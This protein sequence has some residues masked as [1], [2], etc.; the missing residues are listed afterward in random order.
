MRKPGRRLL[1]VVVTVAMVCLGGCHRTD[2]D[3]YADDL[4]AKVTVDAMMGHL[5]TLQDIADA[6]GGNRRS[7][8]PGYQ[9][10]VDYV[11]QALRDKGF[12]VS[13]PEFE[14]DAFFVDE[15]SMTVDGRAI[16]VEAITHSASGPPG[17]VRGRLVVTRGAGC[18]PEDYEGLPARGAVV[19]VDRGKCWLNAKSDAAAEAGAAA[20]VIVNDQAEKV[21]SIILSGEQ[22]SR[23]PVVGVTESAGADLKKLTGEAAV[24]VV[25][26]VEK[27]KARNVIAQTRRGATDSV[28]M[29]GGHLDSVR[30]GP[31]IN[32][33]G[34]GV[35]AI[36]E[37]A[38]QMGSAPQLPYAVRFAFWGGEEEGL[39]G[40][41]H[42]TSSLDVEQLK[43]I[44]L[45]LNFDMIA[46]PNSCFFTSDG[47]QS[48]EPEPRY[49]MQLIPEGSPDIE[50][51]LVRALEENGTQPEDAPFDGRSDYESFT[52]AGIP[53][54]N[55]DTGAEERKTAAQVTLWG[56]EKGVACDPNYH[57]ADDTVANINRET[58]AKT[59]RVVAYMTG[60]FAL[61]QSGRNGIPA[62][63]DR[64]RHV[65]PRE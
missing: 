34:S 2:D 44:A 28:V 35:A 50:R 31:G 61:D 3:S 23:I 25:T 33:N 42:Y 13:T 4:S 38:L 51:M 30:F 22:D 64:T 52:L 45:Y 10:S 59:G 49:G 21:F 14:M 11:A 36:L 63:T 60:R 39:L 1:A 62:R 19:V 29:V 24:D 20:L 9:A 6:H 47:D 43:D 55:L 41:R 58:L 57:S 5:Q 65:P 7:G 26:R 32:D 56:G 15:E 48:G 8:S 18:D 27:V 17:G 12:D 37:T 46:S 53:V 16:D 40:S 54:G